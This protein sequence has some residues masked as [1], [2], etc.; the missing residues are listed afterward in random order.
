MTKQEA[1]RHIRFELQYNKELDD[2]D[3]KALVFALNYMR[4]GNTDD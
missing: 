1:E 4:E 2:R 3:K